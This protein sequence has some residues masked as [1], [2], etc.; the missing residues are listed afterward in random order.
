VQLMAPTGLGGA[1]GLGEALGEA[2][3][4][5]EGDTDGDGLGELT[6][7][8]TTFLSGAAGAAHPASAKA[9]RISAASGRRGLKGGATFHRRARL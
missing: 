7:R 9:Q 5:G 3:G 8:C 4:E 1:G 6:G 2:E